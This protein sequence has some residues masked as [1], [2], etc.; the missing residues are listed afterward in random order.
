MKKTKLIALLLALA[1][2]LC[3]CA[4]QPAEP[5]AEEKYAAARAQ[6]DAG[7]Y[8]AAAVGFEQIAGHQDATQMAEYA[9]ACLLME[10]GFYAAFLF[11][12]FLK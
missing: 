2:L 8:Y 9:H 4:Q 10:D 11:Y 1:L 6:L 5:T 3:G 7:L 12:N